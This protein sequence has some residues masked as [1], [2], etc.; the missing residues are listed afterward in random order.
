MATPAV[1]EAMTI[2][3]SL[4][5]GSDLRTKQFLFVNMSTTDLQI[6]LAGAGGQ[7]IGVLYNTPNTGEAAAVVTA[8]IT[9]VEAGG[10]VTAGDRVKS[11]A[12]GKAVTAAST[13]LHVG[14]AVTGGASADRRSVLLGQCAPL[15]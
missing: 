11:D 1:T 14:V 10:T 8:G 4:K 9:K 6:A 12:S 7:I 2:I 13:D 5:A 3:G 15:S